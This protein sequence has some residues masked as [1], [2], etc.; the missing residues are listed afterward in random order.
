MFMH[1]PEPNRA[2]SHGTS[3]V[4]I[5]IVLNGHYVSL[6]TCCSADDDAVGTR[7]MFHG[8][9]GVSRITRVGVDKAGFNRLLVPY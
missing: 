8:L 9:K 4:E 7:V 5:V 3:G 1:Y 6:I 2:G